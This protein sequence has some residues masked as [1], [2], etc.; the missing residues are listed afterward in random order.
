[1]I[2]TATKRLKDGLGHLSLTS[3]LVRSRWTQSYTP[4]VPLLFETDRYVVKTASDADELDELLK[5]RHRV[6][7]GELQGK[8]K[9]FRIELDHLDLACDHLMIVDRPSGRAVGTY[10]LLSSH[11]FDT[12]YSESEFELGRVKDLPGTKL[13]LG[14][15][16]IE[17][18]HRN[19]MVIQLL[20][21]GIAEYMKKTDT[22]YLLGCSSIQ[23][24]DPIQ[25]ATATFAIRNSG[26]TEETLGIHPRPGYRPEEYGVD[27][28]TSAGTSETAD[29]PPLLVSYLKAGA[30]LGPTPA[31][32]AEFRCIDFFTLLDR[33]RLSPLFQRRFFGA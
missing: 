25:V 1:M 10:R 19:G 9:L 11:F 14:R 15:A 30:K 23:T 33:E 26:Q 20:W 32:D 21:R 3:K 24:I 4:K 28:T 5:L 17:P 18:F 16:C 22:R 8:R 13:E 31:V 7:M 6:F 2:A 12:F 27:L 29:L